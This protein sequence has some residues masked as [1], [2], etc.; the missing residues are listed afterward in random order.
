M[1]IKSLLLSSSLLL[2]ATSQAATLD[3][4]VTNLT[5]GVY[6]APLL[7]SAHDNSTHFY[8]LG[9][10][11]STELQAMAEGGD[12]SGLATYATGMGAVNMEN[13]ASGML[14]PATTTDAMD[15]DT[16][17]NMYLSIVGMMVPT[18]DGFIGLDA[19][20]IPTTTGT[21]T[22]YLNGYDAGTE[23]NNEI[24][25]GPS[26]GMPGTPGIP[27][28]PGGQGGTGATGVT[29]EELNPTV[30]IHRGNMGDTMADGGMSDLDSRVHRWLNPVAKVVITVK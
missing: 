15:I 3:V 29:A 24:V 10:A 26:A 1:K 20:P 8:A 5:H 27:G 21:Y 22:L 18:N 17:D 14:P 19:W 13:P 4:S 2:A 6:F 28:N 30:H 16:G 11:A 23:A 12:I 9:S 25:V 7:I